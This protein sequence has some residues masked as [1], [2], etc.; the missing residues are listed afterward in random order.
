MHCIDMSLGERLLSMQ[1]CF[2]SK[3]DIISDKLDA[4]VAAMS[5][6]HISNGPTPSGLLAASEDIHEHQ[7]PCVTP[8]ALPEKAVTSVMQIVAGKPLF[9]CSCCLSRFYLVGY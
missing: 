3:L 1:Q 2:L 9:L 4:V 7:A 6:C 8:A 5:H